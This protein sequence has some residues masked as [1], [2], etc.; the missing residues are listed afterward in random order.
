MG[1]RT[2]PGIADSVQTGVIG[3]ESEIPAPTEIDFGDEY[4]RGL[5]FDNVLHS[6]NDGD[7]H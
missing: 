4:I 2:E 6:E 7:L 5:H 3:T 1:A